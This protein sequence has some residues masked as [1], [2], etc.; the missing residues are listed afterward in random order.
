LDRALVFLVVAV[1]LTGR[2]ERVQ[3]RTFRTSGDFDACTRDAAIDATSQTGAVRLVDE[4]FIIHATGDKLYGTIPKTGTGRKLTF[5][6]GLLGK[7]IFPLEDARSRG[8]TLSIFGNAGQA[9]FNGHPLTFTQLQ[10]QAGWSFVSIPPEW[11]KSGDN[12]VVLTNGFRMPQD[13]E[14][15]PPRFSLVSRDG[16]G[17]WEPAAGGEFLISLRLRRHPQ[18]GIITSPVIDLANPD[19]GDIIA[20]LATVIEVA[21][22]HAAHTPAGTEV[23]LETRFGDTPLPGRRWP[24]WPSDARR[25]GSNRYMQWR[26]TLRTDNPLV[27]PVLSNVTVTV[28][29][30]ETA[31]AE[32]RGLQL[33]GLDDHPL[34]LSSYP[35]DLQ[36]PSRK[37]K[38][39][40][41]QYRLDEVVAAGRTDFEKLLLL[42]NWVRR[43][44][45]GNDGFGGR[46]DALEILAAPPGKK[47]MCVHYGN[48][49][50]QCAL[51]LGYCARPVIINGHFIADVWS[52][53]H[54]KWVAMD[55][56]AIYPPVRFERFASA[57][58]VDA[59][60][61]DPLSILD[62]YRAYHRALDADAPALNDILQVFTYDNDD[63]QAVPHDMLRPTPELRTFARFAYPPRNDHLDREE[64][65]EEYHGQDHYHSNGYLWWRGRGEHGQ[66]P[67]YSRTSDRPG[68]FEWT[69][70]RVS[71][72]LTPGRKTDRLTVT[73]RTL[74]P[75]FDEFRYRIDG[76]KWRSLGGR[77]GDPDLQ[78]SELD[79]HLHAGVNVLEIKPVNRFGREGAVSRA[80]VKREA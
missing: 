5:S 57:H 72:G 33:V 15:D 19:E 69:L 46:W 32:S 56:E 40:R 17:A 27:T 70:D 45:R 74:T 4:A 10:H 44:W 16:G 11:L 77:S 1:A 71:L 50:S 48:L 26:A 37:L 38:K 34:R 75:N 73:A 21:L 22:D 67:Q 43:Q 68:D 3:E 54:G 39:L 52:P 30:A 76:G 7:K 80:E 8:A 66:S 13:R 62:V 18:S 60:T 20:P 28:R 2:A 49:F 51:S 78:W 23:L 6:A 55:V 9:L 61:R 47:G 35:Y 36:R 59:R 29:L 24:P 14:A 31:S 12:E 79:W 41:E 53:D 42:R 64:P 65:W 58:Y 25:V 63:A